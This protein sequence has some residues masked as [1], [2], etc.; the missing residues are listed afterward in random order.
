MNIFLKVL[1]DSV[2]GEIKS[3]FEESILLSHCNGFL[4]TIIDFFKQNESTKLTR[5]N[6]KKMEEYF[7]FSCS[8]KIEG[9]GNERIL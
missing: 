7:I 8:S 1:R 9:S 2:S 4:M 6:E 5:K 3:I